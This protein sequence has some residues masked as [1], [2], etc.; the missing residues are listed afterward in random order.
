MRLRSLNRLVSA[1]LALSGCSRLFIFGSS[2]IFASFP[3]LD[4]EE[5]P[6]EATYDADLLLEPIDKETAAILS[7]SIGNKSLHHNKHGFYADILHP[8][9]TDPFP[10]GWQDRLV[11]LDGFSNVWALDPHDLGIV[12][13]CV[14]RE[15]DL[16]LVGALLKLKKLDCAK[17]R[18]RF[19]VL[20]LGEKELFRAGRNLGAVCP[21]C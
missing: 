12:K 14:G 9:I 18:E 7:E 8:S 21:A 5:G 1:A 20:P 19:A 11:P 13:L 4:S 15:K 2:S 16:E 10:P 17:L 3:E 6:L